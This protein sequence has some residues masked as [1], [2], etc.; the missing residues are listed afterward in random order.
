[1]TF[2]KYISKLYYVYC[3]F[4]NYVYWGLAGSKSVCHVHTYTHRDQTM[5]SDPQEL[6]HMD[7]GIK[8]GC[9]RRTLILVPTT[10]P[11]QAQGAR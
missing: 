10:P 5:V 7:S 2:R 6:G 11:L 1:M 8:H 3:I 9:S 4:L